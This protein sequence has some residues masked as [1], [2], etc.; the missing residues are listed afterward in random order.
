M[1]ILVDI[2]IGSSSRK[3]VSHD[4]T[5]TEKLK[6]SKRLVLEYLPQVEVD[7][8]EEKARRKYERAVIRTNKRMEKAKEIAREILIFKGFNGFANFEPRR[9]KHREW[10]N[11]GLYIVARKK[12]K[13]TTSFSVAADVMSD[14]FLEEFQASVKALVPYIECFLGNHTDS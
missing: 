6:S 10:V 4:Q 12:D 8:L 14:K 2:V 1:V 9:D 3:V 7:D 13:R 5:S 11:A